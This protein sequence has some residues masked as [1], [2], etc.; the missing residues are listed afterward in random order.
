MKAFISILIFVFSIGMNGFS[1]EISKSDTTENKN[2]LILFSNTGCGK[3][4]VAQNYFEEHKMPYTKYS[5]KDNRPLMYQYINNGPKKK[6]SGVGYP[7]IVYGDSV[8][9]SIKNMGATLSKIENM[10]KS[11]GLLAPKVD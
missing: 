3:C 2:E 8:F 6:K 9:Y 1:Q 11:D 5:I 4:S 7:V 10:M